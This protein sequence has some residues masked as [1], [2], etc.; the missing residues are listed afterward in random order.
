MYMQFPTSN[1]LYYYLQDV[2]ILDAKKTLFVWIGK[3]TSAAEKKNAMQYAHVRTLLFVHI[4]I[5][6][7]YALFI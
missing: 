7:E 4:Y 5:V 1:C 6:Y 3:G 2:F